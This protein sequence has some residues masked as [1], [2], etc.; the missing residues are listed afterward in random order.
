MSTAS[1]LDATSKAILNGINTRLN[2]I[3]MVN[4]FIL[5][6]YAIKHVYILLETLTNS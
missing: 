4:L 3:D 2:E 1:F 6:S 5:V